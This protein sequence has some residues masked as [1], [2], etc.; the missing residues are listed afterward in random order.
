MGSRQTLAGRAEAILADLAG[1]LD[2]AVGEFHVR[3]R[4]NPAYVAAEEAFNWENDIYAF[5][6]GDSWRLNPRITLNAGV[7]WEGVVPQHPRKG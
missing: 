7:R 2:N 4:T 5:Y 1:V 3:S 6:F